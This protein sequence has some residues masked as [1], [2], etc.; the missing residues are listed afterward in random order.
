MGILFA[1]IRV[2]AGT[3]MV[4]FRPPEVRRPVWLSDRPRFRQKP[5]RP[6]KTKTR[7]PAAAA[8]GKGRGLGAVS[9]MGPGPGASSHSAESRSLGASSRDVGIRSLDPP[10]PTPRPRAATIRAQPQTWRGVPTAANRAVEAASQRGGGDP[11]ARRPAAMRVPERA[12]H[13]SVSPPWL[14]RPV[15]RKILG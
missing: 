11:R 9:S 3:G 1:Q 15:R 10:P 2:Q 13:V 12:A 8:T 5:D 7:G 6:L 4:F 14:H